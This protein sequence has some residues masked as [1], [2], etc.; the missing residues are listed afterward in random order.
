ML[1]LYLAT[2]SNNTVNTAMGPVG[3]KPILIHLQFKKLTALLED[4]NNLIIVI[5]RLLLED[6]Y[7]VQV[8]FT[9]HAYLFL[10]CI[11]KA[12]CLLPA[13]K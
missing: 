10:Y 3:G 4:F 5:A 6:I 1:K 7:E 9:F 8:T 12:T 11:Y 13:S 2:K